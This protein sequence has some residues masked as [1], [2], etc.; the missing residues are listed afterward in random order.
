MKFSLEDI[1]GITGARIEGAA[2]APTID[3]LLT[4][5]RSWVDPSHTPL[6]L[7]LRTAT[8]DGH[9]YVKEMYR[10]G[11]R[12]FIVNEVPAVMRNVNDATFLVVPDSMA[13]LRRIGKASARAFRGKIIAIAG[14]RGKTQVK[15]LLNAALMPQCSRSPRSW[16]SQI[17]VP[18]SLFAIDAKTDFA[19]IEAGIDGPGQ[20]AALADMIEPEI[21]ILTAITGEHDGGFMSL[22][23]KI[24][25]KCLL[26]ASCKAVVCDTTEPKALQTLRDMYPRLTIIEATGKNDITEATLGLL[27][28]EPTETR[29]NSM[30]KVENVSTRIDVNEGTGGCLVLSDNFT[31]DIQSLE[32]ALDFMERRTTSGRTN[33]L[34]MTDLMHSASD[35]E[36]QTNQLYARLA[37]MLRHRQISRLIGIGKEISAYSHVFDP[38]MAS[39]FTPDANTFMKSFDSADFDREL[40]LL[41][42]NDEHMRGIKSMLSNAAHDTVMEVNLDALVHNFNAYRSLMPPSAGIVAMVKASAYGIGAIEAS[43]TLQ[44]H[45]AAYLAVAVVDEGVSLRDAGIGMPIMVMNPITTNFRALF[46]YRL[47]PS[48]FSL[49]ELDRIA[50]EAQAADC[51]DAAIHIKLDTGMHR[52]GFSAAELPDL[53][54]ALKGYPF[55]RVASVFSHLATADC[56]DQDEYTQLQ[57]TTFEDMSCRLSELL[58]GKLR[59]HILN[60]AGM[61]RFGS[62]ACAYDMGRLGIG[63]YGIS[64]LPTGSTNIELKPVA[65]LNTTIIALREYKAG[66]T[67]GYGRRGVLKRESVIATLPI[68]YADGIDR[69]LGCGAI[70]FRVRGVDCPTVGSICMDMCMIDVTEVACAQIGDTVEIFGPDLPIERISDALGT[71]PY[72]VLAT[73][74]PRVRRVYFRE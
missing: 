54:E 12:T 61:M 1:A 11:V 72:E 47:E 55:L 10:R 63:L 60:T 2:A 7:A 21:G 38:L 43:K 53:A 70:K 23:Q 30:S 20:M 18:L 8:G 71:I 28:I 50:T 44:S 24:R 69:H 29:K 35:S 19:L 41:R 5:S 27:G 3:V 4:D 39:E 37:D 16:N 22:E 62:Q 73:I 46:N 9:K 36:T 26:F 52:T 6:F 49:K 66:T 48:V 25:E 67:V 57:L 42:G 31:P 14:S 64:P 68:G 59:R 56:L 51:T 33:T 40:I 65:T 58:G 15:E 13:A 17:G 74:S 32:A 45:G 34:I